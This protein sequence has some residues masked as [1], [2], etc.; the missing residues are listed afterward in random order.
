M[1]Q[2]EQTIIDRLNELF[3]LI[4]I[5]DFQFEIY[6]DAVIEA[7]AINDNGKTRHLY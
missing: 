2:I 4:Q 5:D 7:V 3:S 6:P 1:S